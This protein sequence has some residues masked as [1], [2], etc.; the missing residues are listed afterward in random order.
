MLQANKFCVIF[1][2][3]GRISTGM[4]D[5]DTM[6]EYFRWKSIWV[7]PETNRAMSIVV[8]N[9]MKVAQ[10]STFTTSYGKYV[11]LEEFEA[12]QLHVTDNVRNVAT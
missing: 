12:A 7:I 5:F 11:T 6:R 2:L 8:W 4:E 10:M 9:C 1:Y 3:L